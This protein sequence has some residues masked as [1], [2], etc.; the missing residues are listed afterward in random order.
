MIP[1][2]KVPVNHFESKLLKVVKWEKLAPPPVSPA[3]GGNCDIPCHR[4]KPVAISSAGRETNH[5]IP[6]RKN[7]TFD[8]PRW[9]GI[10]GV[11]SSENQ[12][13]SSKIKIIYPHQKKYY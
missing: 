13:N 1:V 5:Y 8:V 12:K 4:G 3:S 7:K 6:C 11:D 9:R 10:K 2:D